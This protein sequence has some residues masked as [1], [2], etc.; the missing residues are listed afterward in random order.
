M[1]AV[2]NIYE[3]LPGSVWKGGWTEEMDETE[4]RMGP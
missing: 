1:F 3:H 4:G 2:T